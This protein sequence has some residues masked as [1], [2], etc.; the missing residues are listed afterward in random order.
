MMA[1]A[2]EVDV[3]IRALSQDQRDQLFAKI[4]PIVNSLSPQSEREV[5]YLHSIQF[6]G[7]SLGWAMDW[8]GRFHRTSDGGVTWTNT[9]LVDA[10]LPRLLNPREGMFRQMHFADSQFGLIVGP[11]GIFASQDSGQSWKTSP[12]ISYFH[13][14]DAVFCNAARSC[15]VAGDEAHTIYWR[16]PSQSV[17]SRQNTPAVGAILAIQFIDDSTGWA[18]SLNGEIIGTVDGGQHWSEL[19]RDSKK[20]FRALHFVTKDIGW[21]VGND[22][23]I[24]K[25]EDGGKTWME[26]KIIAP[27]NFPIH[28][29]RLNAVRFADTTQGWV[30]GQD[31]MIFGTTNGGAHWAIQRFEG[32][33]SNWL[34]IYALAITEGPIVWAAGNSGNIVVSSDGGAFWFPVYGVASLVIDQIR[35]ALETVH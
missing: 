10:T 12:R 1:D 5:E 8:N 31:G 33:Q 30:A 11:A 25:T 7:A 23:V 21:V 16:G 28:E 4:A 17:W 34:T 19:F 13:L 24:M 35:R 29:V 32:P 22:A 9:R 14:M 2:K 15:W 3:K 20:R 18:V 26:Q 27:P 6:Y